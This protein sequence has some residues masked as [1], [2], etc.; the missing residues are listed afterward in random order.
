MSPHIK[1]YNLIVKLVLVE[2]PIDIDHVV[3]Y[4]AIRNANFGMMYWVLLEQD[5]DVHHMVQIGG[6]H[7]LEVQKK[8]IYYLTVNDDCLMWLEVCPR[9]WARFVCQDL[10]VVK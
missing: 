6:L 8:R 1:R 4:F 5:L 9:H 2:F 10:F 7:C 3:A